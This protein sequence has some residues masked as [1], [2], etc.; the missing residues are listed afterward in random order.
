MRKLLSITLFM[1]IILA[2]SSTLAAETCESLNVPKLADDGLTVTL[3]S[4]TTLEKSGS[5]QLTIEYKLQNNTSDKKIDEGSFKLFFDDG[6]SEP[7]YGFFGSF[8]PT[9]STTRS[10]TWEFLKAAKP[11]VISYNAGFFSKEPMSSK[12]NWSPPG[13]VC[14]LVTSAAK[15]QQEAEAKA[16]AELKA[17][18]EAEA[19]AAAELKAKQEAEAKVK[20][21]A[22][23]T[24]STIT[25]S[26]GIQ[27]KK[28]SGKNPKCP[29]GFKRVA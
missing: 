16:A 10:Y 24:K 11:L 8:F 7:Q 13:S 25:C 6:T 18:Q 9:D 3:N 27:R 5:I 12:L 19:K 29:K 14:T 26:K 1:S 28:I 21:A 22:T 15:A 2:P 20:S 4:I 17:K 23:K